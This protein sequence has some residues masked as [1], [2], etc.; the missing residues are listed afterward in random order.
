MFCHPFTTVKSTKYLGVSIHSRLN[1][2]DHINNATV[3]ACKSLTWPNI[4]WSLIH[5]QVKQN[6]Y[7]KLVWPKVP[8]LDYGLIWSS[9]LKSLYPASDEQI[10]ESSRQCC[11]VTNIGWPT[12]ERLIVTCNAVNDKTQPCQ[13]S[14]TA[15]IYLFPPEC[16]EI[17]IPTNCWLISSIQ[18][19]SESRTP[20]HLF[21][22]P[23]F[24]IFHPWYND[25]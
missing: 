10:Q 22:L 17:I 19:S 5:W 16:Q 20:S 8:K 12:L 21:L 23:S 2:S 9:S 25:M 15:K 18:V 4:L 1:G 6:A 7:T 24:P 3:N 14:Y 11:Y 13:N